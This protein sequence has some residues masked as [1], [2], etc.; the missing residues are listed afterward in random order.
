MNAWG[1]VITAYAVTLVATA[2]LLVWS[3]VSMRAAEAA[4]EELKRAE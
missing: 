3:F 4:A 1:F 2:A